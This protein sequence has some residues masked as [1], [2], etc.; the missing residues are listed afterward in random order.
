MNVDMFFILNPDQVFPVDSRLL[1][2]DFNSGLQ[3]Q[4]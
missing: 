1:N 3:K 2:S 4:D